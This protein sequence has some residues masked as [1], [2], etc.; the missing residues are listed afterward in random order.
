MKVTWAI[1]CEGTSTDV[2]NNN[3]S[4]FNIYEELHFPEPPM[5]EG[6]PDQVQ[7]VPVRFVYVATFARSDIDHGE[8]HEARLA[9]VLP[10]GHEAAADP[11]FTVDL[12]SAPRSRVKIEVAMMPLSGEGEYRFQM[13]SLDDQGNWLHLFETPLQV[14]YQ[15]P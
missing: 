7:V 12:E 4:L 15:E 14:S 8:T 10:N 11:H 13:Q 5:Q 1:I 2:E 9:I 6:E 3:V